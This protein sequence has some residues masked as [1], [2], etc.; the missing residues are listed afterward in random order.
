[1]KKIVFTFGRFNPPT[2]GHF[3]LATKVKEEARRRGAEY[4]I[5]GSNTKDS[6]R[7]PLPALDKSRY[8]KKVLKDTNIIVNRDSGN[9]FTVLQQLSKEGYTDVV[10]VVGADRVSEFRN[11]IRKY[12]GKKGYENISNFEVVSAGERDPDAEGVE[13]MSASKMRAA[14]AEGNLNAFKLGIPSHVSEV[15]IMKLFKAIRKGMG[16][17]GKIQESWFDYDEFVEFAESL[18][19][20]GGPSREMSPN[21]MYSIGLSIEKRKKGPKGEEREKKEKDKLEIDDD[22]KHEFKIDESEQLDELSVQSRRKMAKA[23]KRTAKKRARKRKLKEKRRKGKKELV[24]K[25]NKAAIAKV[26]AK[27]IKGM[28]WSDVP[29]MQREKIDAKIK[30]KKKRIA[31]IAK[32]MMPQM[33]KAEKE[34]LAQV[35]ARMTATEPSKA[36]ESI[37]YNFENEILIEDRENVERVKANDAANR[38]KKEPTYYLVQNK[39]KKYLV[40]DRIAKGHT[41]KGEGS[42]KEMK[43]AGQKKYNEVGEEGFHWTDTA[44]FLKMKRTTG[45]GKEQPKGEAK[46]PVSAVSAEPTTEPTV[47]PEV[48]AATDANTLARTN[49]DTAVAMQELEDLKSAQ[50]A[51]AARKEEEER[52]YFLGFANK[53]GE[54]FGATQ[55]KKDPKKAEKT[56]NDIFPSWGHSAV[57]VEHAL[58]LA[59]RGCHEAISVKAIKK[60][61]ED[62]GVSVKD[63]GKLAKSPTMLP[64]GRRLW[65][66]IMK[67]PLMKGKK[68]FHAGKAMAK[69]IKTSQT[70]ADNDATNTTPKTD[71]YFVD[72]EGNQVRL[73]MKIGDGQLMS[74]GKGEAMA[75]LDAVMN[76]MLNCTGR[77]ADGVGT[78]CNEK[79]FDSKEDKELIKELKS[80]KA[81]IGEDF[82]K[83]DLGTGMGPTSWWMKDRDGNDNKIGARGGRQPGFW[84][85]TG[86]GRK[87]EGEGDVKGQNCEVAWKDA[88]GTVPTPEMFK[89]MNK[90][91]QKKLRA[92]QDK[93]WDIM[94]RIAD[95]FEGKSEFA[96]TFKRH[97]IYESM[98]GCGKFCDGCCGMD[99]CESCDSPA[100]ATHMITANKDGTGGKITEIG[101]PNSEYITKMMDNV[102]VQVRVKSNQHDTKASP[103][104]GLYNWYSV[105][106]LSFK[107]GIIE[108]VQTFSEFNDEEN[109]REYLRKAMNWIGNDPFKLLQFYNA[110]VEIELPHGDLAET[111]GEEDSG[112][113]TEVKIGNKTKRIPIK[114]DSEYRDYQREWEDGEELEDES[115]EL[116]ECASL[117][118]EFSLFTEKAP[119]GWEGT[120]KAMKKDKSIDNP[121]ALAHWMK[122]KGYKSRKPV[123][124]S[125]EFK[126]SSVHGLGIFA[127]KDITEGEEI[128]LYYLNLLDLLEDTPSYQRTDFARF[129]NHSY[130]NENISLLENDGNFYAHAVNNIKEGEELFIDYFKVISPLNPIGVVINEVL[131]WTEGFDHLEIE[132]DNNNWPNTLKLFIEQ[133]DCPE[134]AKSLQFDEDYL[135]ALPNYP[136]QTETRDLFDKTLN[137]D[138]GWELGDPPKPLDLHMNPVKE[139]KGD[140]SVSGNPKRAAYLKKYNAQAKQRANR[141]AR[142]LARRELIKQ[143]R[144]AVGD[145]NDVHHKNGNPSDNSPSNLKVTSVK[146]NRGLDNNKWRTDTNEE[147]GA[148]EIGTA[149][150]IKRYLKDTPYMTIDDKF[151]RELVFKTKES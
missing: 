68:G 84:K 113:N 85:K 69:E 144:V 136:E 104:V 106:G 73:S 129:V 5:Y 139:D 100:M 151:A 82:D 21:D 93:H 138:S 105:L 41:K 133:E 35:R 23:A 12:I 94:D 128:S 114:K 36:V 16:I 33:Q 150:L 95:V 130:I 24:K 145:D 66:K 99:I 142:T 75:T 29:F 88:K 110:S 117:N 27:L 89:G 101:G 122:E 52:G 13:G 118:K 8:M 40:V 47:N 120:V 37:D 131:R 103:R 81:Q 7:N 32:K 147:H 123:N 64:A 109:G 76:R 140:A 143:G 43:N 111:F 86:P 63:L 132:E 14:A 62:A 22:F 135:K 46:K 38:K 102:G 78:G 26:R 3:L 96:Q 10:M 1:M 125:Y 61:A 2:T 83:A 48:A 45:G 92:Q 97:L 65:D 28:K 20:R 50:E 98:T 11:G 55:K 42:A 30:K 54:W 80:I 34:R 121:F 44:T 119:E 57:D 79:L 91:A 15:D 17:R 6:K 87:C 70:W 71:V 108:G 60:C 53:I 124:D 9:P 141:S 126:N 49:L 72:E 134:Y 115:D 51:E 31:Q 148:G 67:N 58:V 39:A 90:N 107:S 19:R 137:R 77:N 4:R 112:R 59:S 146:T 25:A 127:K 116:E 56:R 149:E 74:G 18:S